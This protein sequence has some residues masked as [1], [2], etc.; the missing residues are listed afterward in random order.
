MAMPELPFDIPE[1]L[2]SYMSQYQS[3]PE[4]AIY[5]LELHLKKRGMD[6]VG[7]LLLSWMHLRHG[8]T[9]KALEH[10][11]K[12]RAYAPGSPF[13]KHV[14][15]FFS[16]PEGFDAWRPPGFSSEEPAKEA[17]HTDAS[18][19]LDLDRLIEELSRV[20]NKK[21]SLPKDENP[22]QAEAELKKTA[23][24]VQES[25]KAGD[26]ASETLA[27]IYEKQ[28]RYQQAIETFQVLAQ[29]RQHKAEYYALEIERLEQLMAKEP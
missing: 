17:E 6:A 14:H 22:D 25:A 2:S 11:F 29:A 28:K 20:E 4:K 5:G 23:I 19:Q 18:Y 9:E 12:A 3:D 24:K 16:H 27:R 26:I 8:K 21:I 15:Y 1:S 13:L 7:Y 10:A